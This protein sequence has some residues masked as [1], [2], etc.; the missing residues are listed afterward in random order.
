MKSWIEN[1]S[2]GFVLIDG[3]HA[4]EGV[5]SDTNAVLPYAPVRPLYIVL[6]DS[7][8]PHAVKGL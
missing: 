7:F 5:R 1:E 4:A 8:H 6:H 2:L 3:D